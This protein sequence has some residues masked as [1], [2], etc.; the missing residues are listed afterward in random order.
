MSI[1]L[2]VSITRSLADWIEQQA[3]A[4]GESPEEYCLE[5]LSA[6]QALESECEEWPNNNS[7]LN[8]ER[9]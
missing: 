5:I 8:N 3:E 7:N 4:S 9:N 2:T 6:Y 1:K